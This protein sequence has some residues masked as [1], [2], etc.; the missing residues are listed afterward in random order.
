M[1]PLSTSMPTTCQDTETIR[2]CVT[3]LNFTPTQT[4]EGM[5]NLNRIER[6]FLSSNV[7]MLRKLVLG[8]V[9][10]I[11]DSLYDGLS[12]KE[13]NQMRQTAEAGAHTVLLTQ[14]MLLLNVDQHLKE[15]IMTGESSHNR[16][17]VT[18]FMLD[19]RNTLVI[20]FYTDELLTMCEF[21]GLCEDA[22]ILS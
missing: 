8:S 15:T 13:T 3:N 2:Q 19:L 18:R 21:V 12:T 14:F 16:Y 1:Q 10:A 17:K 5:T 11:E 9:S 7:E 6:L 22:H 4:T 20:E